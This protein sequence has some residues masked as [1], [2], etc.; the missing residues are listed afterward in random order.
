MFTH[1]VIFQSHG[2]LIGTDKLAQALR[3]SQNFTKEF[4]PTFNVVLQKSRLTF[5]VVLY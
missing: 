3:I 5:I 2:F 1:S 4:E